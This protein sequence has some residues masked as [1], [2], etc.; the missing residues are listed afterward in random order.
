MD[1]KKVIALIII[2]LLAGNILFVWMYA[3]AK[4]D[5]TLAQ[6]VAAE[7]KKNSGVSEFAKMFVADVLKAEGEVSFD[8]RLKLENAVRMLGDKEILDQ[9]NKFVKSADQQQAQAEVKSLLEMLVNKI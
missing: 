4:K 6:K 9:W 5:L 2:V 8:T 1:N 7:Q 3:G